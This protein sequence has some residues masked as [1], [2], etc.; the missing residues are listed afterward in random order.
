MKPYKC[1]KYGIPVDAAEVFLQLGKTMCMKHYSPAV[2]RE[3]P[4]GEHI[5][6]IE[7]PTVDLSA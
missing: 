1:T 2:P 3:A 6:S 4:E 5:E 7:I